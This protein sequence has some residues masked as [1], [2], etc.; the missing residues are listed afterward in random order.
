[1][2]KAIITN[3]SNNSNLVIDIPFEADI[4]QELAFVNIDKPAREIYLRDDEN[5]KVSMKLF[6]NNKFGNNVIPL[7]TED[8][9]LSA[10]IMMCNILADLPDDMIKE[11][12]KE[13]VKGK[14]ENDRELI[15]D[16][17]NKTVANMKVITR[18]YDFYCPLVVRQEVGY[19]L[20][21]CDYYTAVLYEEEIQTALDDERI[22]EGYKDATNFFDGSKSLKDKFNNFNQNRRT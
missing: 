11:L 20:E 22:R 17:V 18:I 7:F 2:I 16:A 5:D 12:N 1:M 4:V 6:S 19:E 8:Y 15:V 21:E 10:I 3:K 13:I 9:S 14:Y